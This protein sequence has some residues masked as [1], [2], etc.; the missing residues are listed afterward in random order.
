MKVEFGKHIL[1]C[2]Y[3]PGH[4]DGCMTFVLDDKSLAFTGA[5]SFAD[6]A[7]LTSHKFRLRSFYDS[8]HQQVFTLPDSCTLY[9]G[10]DYKGRH[11]T[12]KHSFRFS[13][14]R[15]APPIAGVCWTFDSRPTH[16]R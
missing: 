4:T 10:H 14:R 11:A 7:A 5:S 12:L 6:V 1:E 15:S 3:T 8:I 16:A 9:L 13:F 2:L